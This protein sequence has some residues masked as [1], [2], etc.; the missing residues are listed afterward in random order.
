MY[1]NLLLISKIMRHSVRV[2]VTPQLRPSVIESKSIVVVV[3][4]F[5]FDFDIFYLPQ[6]SERL[7]GFLFARSANDCTGG[8]CSFVIFNYF[9]PSRSH[10]LRSVRF[11]SGCY[12]ARLRSLSL[13]RNYFARSRSHSPTFAAACGNQLGEATRG[14]ISFALIT[15]RN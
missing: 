11:G 15:T 2:A 1:F 9:F 8:F 6:S 10:F 13:R 14:W 3:C 4:A 7:K 12:W 5:L